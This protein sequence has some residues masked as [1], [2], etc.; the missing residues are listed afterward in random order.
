MSRVDSGI[1]F[2]KLQS[3]GSN[4]STAL[5]GQL[6]S[7]HLPVVADEQ[8]GADQFRIVPRNI[9]RRFIEPA[10][11]PAGTIHDVLLTPSFVHVGD[12]E[13]VCGEL[14]PVPERTQKYRH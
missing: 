12:H 7:R 14:A 1:Y 13:C 6:E 5:K 11:V 2:G 9:L 4:K 8:Y 3:I 10:A